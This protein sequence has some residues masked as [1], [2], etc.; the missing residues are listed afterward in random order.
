MLESFGVDCLAIN[1]YRCLNGLQASTIAEGFVL[2]V[3]SGLPHSS[4]YVPLHLSSTLKWIQRVSRCLYYKLPR[5]W[6]DTTTTDAF[7]L[8][9]I[10]YIRSGVAF[11]AI[12]LNHPTNSSPFSFPSFYICIFSFCSPSSFSRSPFRQRFYPSLTGKLLVA[13]YIFF[14]IFAF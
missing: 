10:V 2:P 7:M 8:Y 13:N 9:S 12:C 6:V 1:I 11:S 14:L 3:R 5:V 4:G